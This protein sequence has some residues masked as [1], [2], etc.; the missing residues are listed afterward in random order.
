MANNPS[1]TGNKAAVL[2]F[3]IM[4]ASI[5]FFG[6]IGSGALGKTL[7]IKVLCG[8]GGLGGTGEG[9]GFGGL[10]G[11]VG[12][13]GLGVG[14]GF[15]GLGGLGGFGGFGGLGGRIG[16]GGKCLGRILL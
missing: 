3:C 1:N 5:P 10:G 14:V 9:V 6:A 16:L 12:F 8:L 2:S 13:G 7:F 11:G 15:G 4:G